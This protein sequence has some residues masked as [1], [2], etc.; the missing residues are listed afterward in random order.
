[1]R[2]ITYGYIA[3]FI[4]GEGYLGI[5]RHTHSKSVYGFHYQI[6]V[7]VAQIEINQ[8]PLLEIQKLFGGHISKPRM[9]GNRRPTV[10]WELSNTKLVSR[11]LKEI[12]H[13][14]RIKKPQA[15]ILQ[16]YIAI[17]KM[18]TRIPEQMELQ[19]PVLYQKREELY[20]KILKIN[21]RGLAET[22]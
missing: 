2:E 8:E 11:F 14:L 3:G 6:V 1:M 22:K 15:Q 7:K 17:G 4:D 19:R 12:G 13:L 20:K 21:H 5:R 10:T 18:T 9:E 16:E